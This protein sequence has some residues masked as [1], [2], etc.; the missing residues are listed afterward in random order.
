MSRY[1][2]GIDL[3]ATL[4]KYTAMPENGRP[5]GVSRVPT[6]GELGPEM[7]IS[8][9]HNAISK[10]RESV[11]AG[12]TV[13]GIGIGTPGLIDNKGEII[14][15]AVNIPG[16]RDV[17]LQDIMIKREQTNVVVQND[18]NLTALGELHYGVGKNIRNLVCISIGTGIGG[19]IVLDGKL[20]TGGYGFTGEIGHLVVEPGGLECDCGQNGCLEQYSSANGLVANCFRL[21]EKFPS[22]LADITRRH[23][24]SIT[25]EYIYTFLEKGDKLARE[26]HQLSCRMLA[27]VIGLIMGILA[28]EMVVLCGGVM[29]SGKLILPD[30]LELLP[31]NSI[32]TI[33][34]RCRVLPGE[35]G[36]EA[37]VIG[38]AVYALQQFLHK[39]EHPK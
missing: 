17:D 19:G 8:Q 18:V 28:P 32:S 16:W 4:I 26:V 5:I 6:Y 1:V 24:D 35:L 3:G 36:P 34:E 21:A 31:S 2:I 29:K 22:E 9:I 11:P 14:G 23:P 12:G 25:A 13:I 7:V 15:E 39:E 37:G 10:A 20:Y 27:R 30:I 33:H 38:A